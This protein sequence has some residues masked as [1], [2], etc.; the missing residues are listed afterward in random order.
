MIVVAVVGLLAALALPGFAKAR[1]TSQTQKC[2]ENQRM[3][4]GAIQ[5]YEIDN[6]T[7]L[8]AIKN[9]GVA[10]RSTLLAYGFINVQNAFE[11]PASGT[12]DYDDIQL[13]Y[14]GTDFTNTYC[15]IEPAVH[16]LP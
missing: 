9:N 10:I 1:R 14:S 6:A 7:T 16:I 13:L 11:C 8:D 4:Y 12:K 15:T 3:I 2:I 5:R